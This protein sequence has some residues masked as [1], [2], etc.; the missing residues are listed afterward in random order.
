MD[1]QDA[2][3]NTG[4]VR[5]VMFCGALKDAP[6]D[7]PVHLDSKLDQFDGRREILIRQHSLSPPPPFL[8]CRMPF[9]LL[10]IISSHTSYVRQMHATIRRLK[11]L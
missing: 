3:L 10:W 7:A 2:F 11:R 6:L 4:V 1:C 9:L 5:A 8:M